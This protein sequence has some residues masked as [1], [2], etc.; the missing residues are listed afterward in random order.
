MVAL[1]LNY[2]ICMIVLNGFR[3][4]LVSRVPVPEQPTHI[5][6]RWFFINGIAGS[7]S[8]V[9]NNLDQL[10]YTFGRRVTG[11]HNRT[12]GIIFDLIECVIQRC[13]SYATEDIRIAYPLVKAALLDPDCHKVVLILHSQG[14]IEGGLVID[15]LLDALPQDIL[16]QLEVYTFANAAN[17]FNNPRR[18]WQIKPD[19]LDSNISSQY[20]C[21]IGHIEHYA[22]IA[23]MISCIGVLNFVTIPNRYMG[24]LFIRSG[25]GHMLD[26]HY[27]D[28]M[29]TMGP[30]HKVLENNPFMDMEVETKSNGASHEA[31]EETLCPISSKESQLEYHPTVL[32]VKDYSRLWKYRNGRVPSDKI[33]QLV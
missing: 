29:F 4:V 9:Q 26:Q 6:E 16:R 22:N 8:W 27:L 1:T 5:R 25:S 7:Q 2:V 17:H 32:R 15:W 24:R 10:S 12:L 19:G 3:R 28:T 13:F 33:N 14:G 21:S 18:T 20:D 31:C 30:D 11:I 23:D